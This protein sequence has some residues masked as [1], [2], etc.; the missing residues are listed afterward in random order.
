MPR[1]GQGSDG[2]AH[3]E[4]HQ[5]RLERWVLDWHRIVEYDHH[6]VASVTVERTAV[7]SRAISPSPIRTGEA[8]PVA[9]FGAPWCFSFV[10]FGRRA[11]AAVALT[12]ERLFIGSP[13]GSGETSY[14]PEP[15]G[16]RSA[17]GHRLSKPAINLARGEKLDSLNFRKRPRGLYQ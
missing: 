11:L 14:R 3:F 4:G 8:T 1:L 16:P 15:L 17:I 12:L 5:H 9:S 6:A 2:I 10:D 7:L 13:A